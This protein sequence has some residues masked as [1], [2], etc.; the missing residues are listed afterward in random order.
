MCHVGDAGGAHHAHG[1]PEQRKTHDQ[2]RQHGRAQPCRLTVGN[3]SWVCACAS[4]CV[5]K[6]GVM[7]SL[8]VSVF[9]QVC[10]QE[11][12]WENIWYSA[13][14]KS[15]GGKKRASADGHGFSITPLNHFHDLAAP[16]SIDSTSALWFRIAWCWTS[17]HSFSHKFWS[18][19]ASKQIEY[20]GAHKRRE[21]RGKWMRERCKKT[22]VLVAQYLRPDSWLFWTILQWRWQR[23]RVGWESCFCSYLLY[24]SSSFPIE[25]EFGRFGGVPFFSRV[26]LF[27]E[28]RVCLA[29]HI[30]LEISN[31]FV[32]FYIIPFVF[33]FCFLFYQPSALRSSVRQ[34]ELV[35]VPSSWDAC[36]A[37]FCYVCHKHCCSTDTF[38]ILT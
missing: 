28:N 30:N 17:N 13:Q 8:K 4:V 14:M 1:N 37:F 19:L 22:D 33:L 27:S 34:F 12:K 29:W 9:M 15:V 7:G 35:S 6:L 38:V 18:E 36:L 11:R 24:F 3:G 25:L 21:H 10:E 32:I 16:H 23:V 5:R 26:C 2:Q 31:I 20:S